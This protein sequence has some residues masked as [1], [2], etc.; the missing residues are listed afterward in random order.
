MCVGKAG[1]RAFPG[2]EREWRWLWYGRADH[3]E[4]GGGGGAGFPRADQPPD[5]STDRRRRQRSDIG[6]RLSWSDDPWRH[7]DGHSGRRR[8]VGARE[9]TLCL[10]TWRRTCSRRVCNVI[11]QDG[12][13]VRVSCDFARV[14]RPQGLGLG[15]D[16]VWGRQKRRCGRSN[17]RAVFQNIVFFSTIKRSLSC[18]VSEISFF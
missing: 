16:V 2:R 15:R 17:N 14:V 8:C 7:P 11:A 5:R 13:T 4:G 9:V 12:A 1:A 3:E 6:V 10:R 18:D